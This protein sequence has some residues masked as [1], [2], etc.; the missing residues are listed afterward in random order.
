MSERMEYQTGLWATIVRE[1]KQLV[2]RP[3]YVLCMVGAPLFSCI[4]LL[5][6]MHEGLPHKIPVAIVDH[7]HTSTSRNFIQQLGSQES[8][9]VA[10][11][12]NSFTEARELMQ[13]GDIF[14]FLIIPED[15]EAKAIAGRQPEISFYTNDAYYIPAS[16]L[17]KKFQNHVGVSFG[18]SRAPSITF[19]GSRGVTDYG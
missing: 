17:Y 11:K 10:Y 16:L 3:I 6:L 19:C 14:G 8:V 13:S 5:S 15:F 1:L 9:D 18:C 4:F 2:S 7:D 12:L